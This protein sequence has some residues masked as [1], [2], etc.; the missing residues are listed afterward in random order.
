MDTVSA[1]HEDLDAQTVRDRPS[2]E[3]SA[4]T[5]R[6]TLCCDSK[7]QGFAQG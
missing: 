5:M 7:T 3:G 4:M 6:E 2:W 1:R